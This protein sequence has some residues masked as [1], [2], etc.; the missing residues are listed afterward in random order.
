MTDTK[1]KI[2]IVEDYPEVRAT[3][4]DILANGNYAFT[5]VENADQALVVLEREEFH[6]LIVDIGLGGTNGLDLIRQAQRQELTDAP[7]I[8]ITGEPD[9]KYRK[10]AEELGIF[11]YFIKDELVNS[12]LRKAVSEAIAMRDE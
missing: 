11:R 8:V 12:D 2:L 5:E 10:E 1:I 3:L 7:V 4:R 9:P 6:L